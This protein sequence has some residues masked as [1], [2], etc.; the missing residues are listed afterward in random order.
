MVKRKLDGTV[1]ESSADQKTCKSDA[2][3]RN[4]WKIWRPVPTAVEP[5]LTAGRLAGRLTKFG[6]GFK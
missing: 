4:L 2:A 3:V 5:G 1:N 6:P